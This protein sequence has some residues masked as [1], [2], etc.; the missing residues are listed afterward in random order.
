MMGYVSKFKKLISQI[1]AK[2]E[3]KFGTG[4]IF[5]KKPPQPPVLRN[6]ME[7]RSKRHSATRK[8]VYH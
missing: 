4:N 3:K 7:R 2:Y 8:K 5:W 1:V 6:K